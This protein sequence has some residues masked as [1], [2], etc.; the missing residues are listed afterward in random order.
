MKNAIKKRA[1]RI[2]GAIA[3]RGRDLSLRSLRTLRV[4]SPVYRVISKL[5]SWYR[6]DFFITWSLLFVLSII[7]VSLAVSVAMYIAIVDLV[8]TD[9][10]YQDNSSMEIH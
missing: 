2:A 5:N 6:S 8:Y 9:P 7:S 1:L 3:R 10:V 4:S